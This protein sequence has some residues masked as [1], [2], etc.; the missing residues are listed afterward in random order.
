MRAL[1][2]IVLAA[3]VLSGCA[4][5]PERQARKMDEMLAARR[6][7]DAVRADQGRELIQALMAR[8]ESKTAAAKATPT[9]LPPT[10]D[11]LVI[12]GGGDW[13]ASC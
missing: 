8:A 6:A 3:A 13:G 1:I 10:I 7:S 2:A 11:I 9:G 4:S 5:R 12:S